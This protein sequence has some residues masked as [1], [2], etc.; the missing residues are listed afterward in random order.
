MHPS[1]TGL[2]KIYSASAGWK[3]FLAAIGLPLGLGGVAGAWYF[4]TGHEV[5]GDIQMY[6]MVAISL[7]M[8]I[9]G[10]WCAISPL[11]TKILVLHEDKL[12]VPGLF[13]N[14]VLDRSKISGYRVFAY[15]GVNVLQL[16]FTGP[17]GS[18][19][20]KNVTLLF[21]PDDFLANWFSVIPNIDAEEYAESV[22]EIQKDVRLGDTPEERIGN[23]TRAQKISRTLNIGSLIL[24][25]WA[26]FY[27]RPYM[28]IFLVLV[29]LPL[30]VLW[31]CRRYPGSFSID[32]T[33]KK[34]ARGD[35]TPVLFMPGFVLAIRAISDVQ[36]LAPSELII[37]TLFGALT[38]VFS[39]AWVAPI[40]RRSIGKLML[41]T[42]ILAAYPASVIA[43][44]NTL[45]DQL[46]AEQQV[47]PVLGKY[48]TTGKG[49]SQ[50]FKVSPQGSAAAIYEILVTRELYQ[51]TE[52]GQSICLSIHPGALGLRWYS[53]GLATTCR[54]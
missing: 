19:K 45:F 1:A 4:G 52:I 6:L 3:I 48:S 43:I 25:G 9:L 7:S 28:P 33:G 17:S 47:L 14:I 18:L 34:T 51:H 38:L 12:V 46:S 54:R 30:L 13:R 35:L 50:Y 15:Q 10:L 16:H 36:M 32:D 44:A 2:P 42:A 29:A 8:A 24:G 41:V 40:Y 22:R 21:T 37:P 20:M 49:A 31:L 23:V 39:I 11:V 53:A 27:P 5:R 26:I